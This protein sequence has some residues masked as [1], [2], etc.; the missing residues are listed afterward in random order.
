MALLAISGLFLVIIPFVSQ[1]TFPTD[2]RY[3]T[4]SALSQS[5]PEAL[6]NVAIQP[7]NSAIVISYRLDIR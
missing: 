1:K 3:L 2:T 7:I 6:K 4:I 5:I